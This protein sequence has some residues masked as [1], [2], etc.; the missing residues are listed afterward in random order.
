[1]GLRGKVARSAARL[2]NFE[3]AFGKW[4]QQAKANNGGKQLRNQHS[5]GMELLSV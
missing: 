4:N 5:A 2:A 1:M 3:F